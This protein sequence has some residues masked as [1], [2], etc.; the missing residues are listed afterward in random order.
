M[1]DSC[2]VRK[3]TGFRRSRGQ[4]RHQ[5]VRT[6]RP[7]R[8]RL[9]PLEDRVVPDATTVIADNITVNFYGNSQ[10]PAI[11]VPVTV[12]DN[13]G[14][15]ATSGTVT[16]SLTE[17]NTTTVLG[18]ATVGS[19][20]VATVSINTGALPSELQP[21][22]FTLE[23]SFSGS[24]SF[25]ASFTTGTLTINTLSTTVTP[26]SVSITAANSSTVTESGGATIP[27]GADASNYAVLYEGVDGHTLHIANS[28]INGNVGV[29]GTG[30]AHLSGPV[31]LDGTVDFSASGSGQLNEDGHNTTGP[32]A[33]N[34]NDAAVTA[35]LSAVNTLSASLA[36]LGT[37]IA[38]NG[39]GTTNESEGALV[40]V[41]GVSYRVFNVTSFHLDDH[42]T[43][44]INGDG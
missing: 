23:E 6:R 3:I 25:D 24:G 41:N 11:I 16:I 37:N 4:R 44:T 43:L 38:I 2:W 12:N 10:S 42:D 22:T 33:V 1:L 13:A 15:T 26:V 39:S 21:G 8:L 20:G 19:N 34:V 9:E 5:A 36:G 27:I 7:L 32:S 31:D 30:V 18:S 40:T 17:N 29:G 28:T 14:G 35:A